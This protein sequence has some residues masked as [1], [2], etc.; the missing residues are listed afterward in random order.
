MTIQEILTH[1]DT[2]DIPMLIPELQSIGI[3]EPHCKWPGTIKRRGRAK[4]F[5]FYTEY[6]NCSSLLRKPSK[7]T[8]LK[9]LSCGE[10]YIDTADKPLAYIIGYVYA[11]RWLSRYLQ[12]KRIR[13]WV[14]MHWP[15]NQS[16]Y[17]LLGVPYGWKSFSISAEA[18]LGYIDKQYNLAKI[19]AR[20][21]DISF[22]VI[23]NANSPAMRTECE[24]RSWL[25]M[26]SQ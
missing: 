15:T 20:S 14:D 16:K 7:L 25:Y 21:D 8:A 17:H 19:H 18:D 5:N 6:I 24:N 22:L 9:P 10:I 3:D 12:E 26:R 11:K 1:V 23:D 2:Y 4:S 13:I